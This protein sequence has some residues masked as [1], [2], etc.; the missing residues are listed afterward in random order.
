M[1]GNIKWLNRSSL[2]SIDFYVTS[3]KGSVKNSSG[4]EKALRSGNVSE[5]PVWEL[6]IDGRP[7][8]FIKVYKNVNKE[9]NQQL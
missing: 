2:D 9:Q 8:N 4:W 3:A 1:E 5:K 6:D 7:G